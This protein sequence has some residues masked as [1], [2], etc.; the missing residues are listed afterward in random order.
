MTTKPESRATRR[1]LTHKRLW[2][3]IGIVAALAVLAG[4]CATPP[5]VPPTT[6]RLPAIDPEIDSL[7]SDPEFTAQ[8][9]D[10]AAERDSIVAA[11][12][13]TLSKDSEWGVDPAV[14][15][16]NGADKEDADSA[17]SDAQAAEAADLVSRAADEKIRLDAAL[18][19]PSLEELQQSQTERS[20]DYDFSATNEAWLA[21]EGSAEAIS[22]L[23]SA[24]ATKRAEVESVRDQ[25]LADGL[26]EAV[27]AIPGY[28]PTEGA[29]DPQWAAIWAEALKERGPATGACVNR[30]SSRNAPK[31]NSLRPGTIYSPYQNTFAGSSGTPTYLGQL[32][33]VIIDG[34]RNFIVEGHLG[35]LDVL[36]L[37]SWLEIQTQLRA[38]ITI[39]TPSNI[40]LNYEGIG[41]FMQ[42]GVPGQPLQSGQV[43][44]L[45]YKE[46][47][48]LPTGAP[49]RR[50]MF[51]AFIPMDAGGSP[52]A[53]PGFQVRAT[54]SNL[55]INPG[56]FFGADMRTV[57]LG[58]APLGYGQTFTGGG[59]GLSASRGVIVDDNAISVD[60]LESTITSAVNPA[61]ASA[62]SGLDGTSDWV[63]G[64]KGG[65]WG[66]F[67]FHINNSEPNSP[68]VDLDWSQT[69]NSS[70]PDDE[71][72]LKGSLTIDDWLVEG[73]TS[74]PFAALGLI[75]C[76]WRFKI[77]A[78]AAIYAAVD[79]NDTARTILQPDVE[80]GP[81]S[82][83]VHN[84]FVSPIPLGCNFLYAALWADKMVEKLNGLIPAVNGL[85]QNKLQNQT[86]LQAAVP[87]NIP[88]GGNS[89][90][91]VTFA[92]FNDTCAP[93]ACNGN[94]AGDVAMSWAGLEATADLRFS[95]T[96]P[97]AATR[98]FPASYSPTTGDTAN[99]RVRQHFGPQNEITDFG[100][101][102][103]PSVLN[104]ALR[105]MAEHGRLDL[106][107]SPATPAVA[108]SAPI[109]LSKPIAADKPLGIFLPHLEINDQA[110]GN[111]YALDALAA[112]GVGFDP[113]TRKLVPNTVSP[114]DPS[115]AIAAWTLKCSSP[116]WVTCNGIPAFVSTAANWVANTLL[117]PLLQ[118]S[119]GQVTI[120]TT[121]NFTLTNLKILNEDGHLG[122]RTSVGVAQLRAWGGFDL[123]QGT[124]NFFT[125]WEGLG[126][127]GP[128]TYT[129]TITDLINNNVLLS[130]T[131]QQHEFGSLPISALS[132]FSFPGLHMRLVKATISATRG[133][134]TKFAT[135]TLTIPA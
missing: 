84:M 132:V 93:Y 21:T 77:D 75:P 34:K 39:H 135:H 117:D 27:D 90:M 42:E 95:D 99:G 62:M 126:G 82:L 67:G 1:Q 35:D 125:F 66:W 71:Y 44:V 7:L 107:S 17:A 45:C 23:E 83:N 2:L 78:S 29:S 58:K 25:L 70:G 12:R 91:Q 118:N 98:R 69:N 88:I 38:R 18:E 4:A 133:P 105:V 61:L 63:L 33:T 57:H 9:G 73:Y 85:L 113:A 76:Y 30:D 102:V 65:N 101:W 97:A 110:N 112:V 87:A 28:V 92:G 26:L 55:A 59:I 20:D 50:A 74:V 116:L 122:I 64:R 16:R 32:K 89:N 11:V 15:A 120:P 106:G 40:A 68:K 80:I 48:S 103:N 22:T 60:D 53:E 10:T 119:I 51:R 14:V 104:Q 31:K 114:T 24:Y 124:Y 130:T 86:N 81:I 47:L 56:F 128:V 115:F 41:P 54:I 94:H 52:L 72:R 131:S 96:K 5:P 134:D 79:V 127:T 19:T 13:D 49:I 109:Y 46:D 6:T 111:I 100:A 3:I 36:G 123:S 108:R 129:W 8:F 121:G 37:F 43:Q